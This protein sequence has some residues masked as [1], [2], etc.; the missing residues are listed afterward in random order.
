MANSKDRFLVSSILLLGVVLRVLYALHPHVCFGDESCYIWLAKT[1]FS[2]AQYSYCDGI[3]ELHFP[4]LF[5]ISLAVIHLVVSDWE[6]VT[7][8]AYVVFGGL[9]PLPVYLLGKEMHSRRVG[10][11]ACLLVA[12]LPALTSG[13]LLAETVSEPLYLLCLFT[14]VYLVHHGHVTGR[15]TYHALGGAVLSLAY[16]T[17][18][19]GLLYLGACCLFLVLAFLLE[20]SVRLLRAAAR[21]ATVVVAFFL[22]ASPYLIYLHHHV[23]TWVLTTKGTTTYKT[24]RGLVE[25][26][27]VAFQRDTWGLTDKGEVRYFA[28]EFDESLLQLLLGPYRHRVPSDVRANF[29]YALSVLKRPHVFGGV[30][31]L[32]AFLGFLGSTWSRDRLRAE[33]LSLL[34]VAP[35]AS[36]LVFFVTERYLYS[37]L[38][39][40]TLWASLGIRNILDWIRGTYLPG[41][42]GWTRGRTALQVLCVAALTAYLLKTG[43]GYFQETKDSRDDVWTVAVWLRDNTPADAV[44]MTTGP[45]VAFH[46][47]RRWLPLPVGTRKEVVAYG[48]RRGATHL[49]LRKYYALL[50]PD[51]NAELFGGARDFDDLELLRKDPAFVAYRLKPPEGPR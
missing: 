1:I 35:L 38:L 11:L 6:A 47:H 18:P 34:L 27:G 29:S 33:L 13:V 48:V 42:L 45:E 50:R 28:H 40:L 4:P 21:I 7:R 10:L 17:R 12:I 16:L 15:W 49:C 8:V 22:V 9:I 41:I 2:S 31:M 23:G 26:D 32:I 44:V 43:H 46:A 51:Q 25:H 36:F 37:M 39:P 19:E 3:Q 5:P 24:T 14:G 30:L 20:R